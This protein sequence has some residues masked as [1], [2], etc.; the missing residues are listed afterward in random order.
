MLTIGKQLRLDKRPGAD[1]LDEVDDMLWHESLAAVVKKAQADLKLFMHKTAREVGYR[2]GSIP[3]HVTGDYTLLVMTKTEFNQ[4]I[5]EAKHDARKLGQE[6]GSITG[7]AKGVGDT[8]KNIT[9]AFAK[10]IEG[11]L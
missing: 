2:H 9:A 8:A 6:Q 7:Y 11:A 1:Q 5:A 4:H 10:L 3:S